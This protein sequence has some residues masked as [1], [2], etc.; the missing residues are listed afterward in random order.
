MNVGL[1]PLLEDEALIFAGRTD[2][3][4]LPLIP[5]DNVFNLQ[6][7]VFDSNRLPHVDLVLEQCV[8]SAQEQA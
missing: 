5:R 8:G 6:K 7:V 4:V 1:A 2:R 3:P